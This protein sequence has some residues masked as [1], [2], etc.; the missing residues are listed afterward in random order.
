[1][2]YR[3]EGVHSILSEPFYDITESYLQSLGVEKEDKILYDG[4]NSFCSAFYLLNR[5]G[6]SNTY[7]PFS[8]MED[9]EHYKNKGA[10]Y[11][12]VSGNENAAKPLYKNLELI[13]VF[14]QTVYIYKL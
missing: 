8:T 7:N 2:F 13:D 5:Y 3:Y 12:F 6:W 1:M 9:I 14:Q 10:K 4:E 11:L